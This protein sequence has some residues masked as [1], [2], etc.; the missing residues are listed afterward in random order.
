MKQYKA[1]IN[2]S[3]T[4]E[5]MKTILLMVGSKVT[6]AEGKSYFEKFILGENT[7]IPNAGIGAVAEWKINNAIF[8][9]IK[10]RWFCCLSGQSLESGAFAARQNHGYHFIGHNN[11]L[12]A[13]K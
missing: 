10:N 5:R 13:G 8:S 4:F 2:F 9:A 7:D 11:L 6:D 1:E 3:K 12:S